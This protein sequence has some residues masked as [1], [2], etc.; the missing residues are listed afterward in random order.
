MDLGPDVESGSYEL[1]EYLHGRYVDGFKAEQNRGI[2]TIAM[3]ALEDQVAQAVA[4]VSTTSFN[5][6][7][8]PLSYT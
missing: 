4:S 8:H 1:C 6:A 2:P 5:Q 7:P 3:D